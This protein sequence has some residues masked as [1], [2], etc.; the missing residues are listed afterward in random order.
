[1]E[2]E[3]GQEIVEFG[4]LGYWPFCFLFLTIE[5]SYASSFGNVDSYGHL[6]NRGSSLNPAF[7]HKRKPKTRKEVCLQLKI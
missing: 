3:A 4:D 6:F 7:L 2:L 1:M 5:N